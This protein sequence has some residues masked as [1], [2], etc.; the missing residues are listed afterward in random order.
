MKYASDG[1]SVWVRNYDGPRNLRDDAS[2][3]AIDGAGEV[4]VTGSATVKYK[5]DG[6][7][8]WFKDGASAIAVDDSGNVCVTGPSYSAGTASDFTTIKYT[9]AGETLWVRRYNGPG[10]HDDIPR[11]V[12]LDESGNVVVTGS[13]VGA[14]MAADFATVKYSPHG[15]SLWVRRYNGLPG[16]ISPHLPT[17]IAVDSSNNVYVTGESAG[18]YATIKYNSEGDTFW[19][20]RYAGTTPWGDRATAMAVDGAGN[21]YVTGESDG[22]YAT[23][24]YSLLGDTLWIRR[25]SASGKSVDHASCLKVDG[26]GNVVVTGGS[27][28]DYATIKYGP[29]GDTVWVRTYDGAGHGDDYATGLVIDAAGDVYVTGGSWNGSYYDYAT[30]KYASDGDSLWAI[31]YDGP[32]QDDDKAVA[33]A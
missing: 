26:S 33:V 6:E 7:T 8:Q 10:N 30:I 18:E 21:V 14:D 3:L 1:D 25:H 27:G 20:R 24:K 28:G 19:V 32:Q 4:Y 23:I 12:A 9:P 17:A 13:S 22:D 31:R 5:A 2:G 29:D 11:A 15:D 16:F